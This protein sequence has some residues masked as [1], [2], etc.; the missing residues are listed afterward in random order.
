MPT[1]GIEFSSNIYTVTLGHINKI[2][3]KIWLCAKKV[4]ILPR[5]YVIIIFF[6]DQGFR[7]DPR[8]LTARDK[9]YKRVVNDTSIFKVRQQPSDNVPVRVH[10]CRWSTGIHQRATPHPNISNSNQCR[11]SGS[12]WIHI[13]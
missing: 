8:F 10:I 12:A 1:S 4:T 3:R 11:R 6:C 9:A 7:A 5:C 13:D 2:L